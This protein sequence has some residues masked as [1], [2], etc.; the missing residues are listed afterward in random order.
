MKCF[1]EYLYIYIYGVWVSELAFAYVNI[2]STHVAQLLPKTH[3]SAPKPI[4]SMHGSFGYRRKAT[5]FKW[6][7]NMSEED[8]RMYTSHTCIERNTHSQRRRYILVCRRLRC[9]EK[10]KFLCVLVLRRAI[11]FL[12]Y[13]FSYTACKRRKWICWVYICAGKCLMHCERARMHNICVYCSMRCTIELMWLYIW[14]KKSRRSIRTHERLNVNGI[15]GNGFW[16]WIICAYDDDAK[17]M[18]DGKEIRN[19]FFFFFCKS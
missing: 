7:R 15:I 11:I 1:Y 13:K 4:S 12:L 18:L 5:H 6:M 19:S 10:A 3:P 16:V 2:F 9:V 17:K 14:W 8:I